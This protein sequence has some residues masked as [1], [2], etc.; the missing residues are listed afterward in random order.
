MARALATDLAAL[1][2]DYA[3]HKTLIRSQ[4]VSDHRQRRRADVVCSVLL[5]SVTGCLAGR[6]GRIWLEAVVA[7]AVNGLGESA[8]FWWKRSV[9][10]CRVSCPP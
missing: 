7:R 2:Q 6:D 3:S 5:S 1:G 8:E 4:A 9:A 10:R